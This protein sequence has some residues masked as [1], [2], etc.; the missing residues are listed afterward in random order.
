MRSVEILMGVA[1]AVLCAGSM[2]AQTPP[3]FS[4]RWTVAPDPP[5]AATQGGGRGTPS[6]MG[7]GW[8]S[9]ITVTQDATTLTIEYAQ[10]GRYDMQPPQKLVYLPNGS[11]STNT[12]N[13]GRGPQEMVS[14]AAW[15]GNRLVITTRY[16]F[17]VARDAKPMTSDITQVLSLAA[18]ASL[19]V[20]TTRGAVMGGQPST[21][22]T[23]YRK[24]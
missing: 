15:D 23:I 12:V 9:D 24:N 5:P 7:S 21:T 20:E 14:R 4:G 2:A 1:A 3:D 8:G 6:T 18:P 17:T 13:M 11:E 19:V 10:F 22:K 16:T